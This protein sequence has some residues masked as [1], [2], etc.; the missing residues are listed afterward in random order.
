MLTSLIA[1]G[2]GLGLKVADHFQPSFWQC[3]LWVFPLPWEGQVPQRWQDLW[4]SQISTDP[5]GVS[6]TRD[7]GGGPPE[8]SLAANKGKE[9]LLSF[10]DI[11][12]LGCTGS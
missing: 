11:Y 7:K 12:L 1:F 6:S 5:R 10:F 4:K 8:K 3:F 9:L 2:R